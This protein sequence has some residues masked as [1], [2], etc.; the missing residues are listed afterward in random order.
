MFIDSHCH[1]ELEEYDKD[2]DTVIELAHREGVSGMLTVATEERYFRKAVEIAES[3]PT[4]HAAIGI[5]PHNAE[6]YSDALEDTIRG[7]LNH[8]KVVGYGE[9]GL[10]F[11]RDY[12]PRSTQIDVFRRQ[13]AVAH[14]ASLPIII[15]SRN[16]RGETLD[17]LREL[18]PGDQKVIIHCYSYDMS[19]AR[20]LLD[21]GMYLSIPGTITYKNS[22]L[23]E[24]VRY[25]PLDRLLSETDAPFLTPH[26]HRGKRN[27]PAFV[28]LVTEEI[29]RLKGMPVK[30]TAAV[31][32]TTFS[33]IFFEKTKE[34]VR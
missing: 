23:P 8:P 30:E 28:R 1:L 29:A 21:M 3:H 18:C 19:T 11:Y 32:A 12:A 10:D 7:Y 9:I 22:N 31:L 5:H 15:H 20:S 26:P 13:I 17:V 2:R 33:T 4:V 16:A 24:I 25:V 6:G 14:S 34:I 27:Q